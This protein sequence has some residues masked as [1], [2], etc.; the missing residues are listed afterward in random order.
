MNAPQLYHRLSARAH[1]LSLRDCVARDM[2]NLLNCALRGASLALPGE[3]LVRS[4]V[5]NY[6]NPCMLA[7]GSS[8]VDPLQLA[9]HIRQTLG[10]F[11][12]RLQAA[13]TTVLARQDTDSIGS[14]ALYF[15]VHGVLRPGDAGVAIRLRLDYLNGFF[16]WVRDAG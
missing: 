7:M 5:L 8:R 13:R 12:P 10:Q 6:G 14:S 16:S 11:E 3:A 9:A 1:R 4:S 15:D 2:V